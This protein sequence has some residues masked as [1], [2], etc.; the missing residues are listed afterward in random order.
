[1]IFSNDRENLISLTSIYKHN[2][3]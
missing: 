2:N 3:N 1:M